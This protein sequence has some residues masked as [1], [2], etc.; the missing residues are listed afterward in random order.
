MYE[1][2]RRKAYSLACQAYY[3]VFTFSSQQSVSRS[4]SPPRIC[5]LS[6]LSF[7]FP[8]TS[9]QS[10]LSSSIMLSLFKFA[11]MLNLHG[12]RLPPNQVSPSPSIHFHELMFIQTN[13]WSILLLELVSSIR[14]LKLSVVSNLLVLFVLLPVTCAYKA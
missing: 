8:N 1:G 4:L 5:F 2:M 12:P 10:R 14:R 3:I 13:H 9:Y 11:N 7:P 6:L